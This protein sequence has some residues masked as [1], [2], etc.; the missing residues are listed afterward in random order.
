MNDE[1]LELTQEEL[2]NHVETFARAYQVAKSHGEHLKLKKDIEKSLKIDR[3]FISL[4]NEFELS[5]NLKSDQ[6]VEEL[7]PRPNWAY[8]FVSRAI[9]CKV[10]IS[11]INDLFKRLQVDIVLKRELTPK[12]FSV[13][14]HGRTI[15]TVHASNRGT[16]INVECTCGCALCITY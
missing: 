7:D 10:N 1:I 13:F 6:N 14:S 2:I 16:R 3:N 8:W 15:G 9:D 12:I 4:I 11:D 5:S